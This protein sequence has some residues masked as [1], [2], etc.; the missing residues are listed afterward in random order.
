SHQIT[1]LIDSGD[2]SQKPG[3]IRLSIHPTTTN[4]ELDYCLDAIAALAQNHTEWAN[5]YQ[6][7]CHTNEYQPIAKPLDNIEISQWF[8]FD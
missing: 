2:L 6:Y 1:D 7:D 8:S 3:W 4:K 5:D